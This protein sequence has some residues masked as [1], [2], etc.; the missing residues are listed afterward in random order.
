M[1]NAFRLLWPD[2]WQGRLLRVA[3]L[4]AAA[5][6]AGLLTRAA[7]VPQRVP[8][9]APAPAAIAGE[10]DAKRIEGIYYDQGPEAALLALRQ[11]YLNGF[12]DRSAQ[13]A[14]KLEDEVARLEAH[15]THYLRY[16]PLAAIATQWCLDAHPAGDFPLHYAFVLPAR[17]SDPAT[18]A[19]EVALDQEMAK[20]V[21]IN[22]VKFANLTR[23]ETRG[24]VADEHEVTIKSR[25]DLLKD[26]SEQEDVRLAVGPPRPRQQ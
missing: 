8:P 14:R 22:W 3:L 20:V 12:A 17:A 18:P 2:A 6:A 26:Q 19:A 1:S 23:S 16:S 4:L 5:A 9:P 15:T 13:P 11:D 24:Y 25:S 10:D 21:Q 7:P